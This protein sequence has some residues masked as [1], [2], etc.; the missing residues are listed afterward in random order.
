ML[1][2]I[3]GRGQFPRKNPSWIQKVMD[4]MNTGEKGV[5]GNVCKCSHHKTVTAL[6]LVF[7]LLFLLNALGWLISDRVLEIVWPILVI[8]AGLFEMTSG[9]CKCC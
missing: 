8:A 1:K 3:K 5:H 6:V 7:G 2:V 4:M 9:R